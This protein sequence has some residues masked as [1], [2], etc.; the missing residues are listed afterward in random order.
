MN[1]MSNHRRLFYHVIPIFLLVGVGCAS[2]SEV[3]LPTLAYLPQ[4]RN[5]L[6]QTLAPPATE[7]PSPTD[8]PSET[9][10]PTETSQPSPSPTLLPTDTLTPTLTA[11]AVVTPAPLEL[12]YDGIFSLPVDLRAP[13]WRTL[14]AHRDVLT[15]HAYTVSAYR[16]IDGWAKITLVP[17]VLVENEWHTIEAWHD[18]F[19]ELIGEQY[20]TRGWHIYL[21]DS[22]EIESVRDNIPADFVNLGAAVPPLY[23]EYRFPWVAGQGWWAIEGWHSGNALDFQP[24]FSVGYSVLAAEAGILKEICSDGFQSLLQITHADGNHTYYLHVKLA[25]T[26]RHSLLDQPIVRGQYLGELIAD[27]RFNRACGLGFSRHLHFVA[28]DRNLLIEGIRL[29]DIAAQA[30]CCSDPPIFIS[31]NEKVIVQD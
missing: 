10:L 31:S 29:D 2:S 3:T 6:S 30:G 26:V 9:P 8:L 20:A 17:T 27:S 7:T 4:P 19:I 22:P 5:T 25:G 28:S 14:E 15:H 16:A 21:V 1:T 23:G 13:L 11:T 12:R 24:A 18:D